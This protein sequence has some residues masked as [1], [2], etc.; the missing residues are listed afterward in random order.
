MTDAFDSAACSVMANA[1][2]IAWRKI[3]DD[4]FNGAPPQRMKTAVAYAIM[5]AA[6]HG[7]QSEPQLVEYAL[8]HYRLV[9]TASLQ[10]SEQGKLDEI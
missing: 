2:Q 10:I 7:I 8:L 9:A 5:E 3:A 6:E 4:S 1:L